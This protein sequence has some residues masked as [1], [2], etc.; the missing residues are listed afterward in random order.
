MAKA[1]VAQT[2]AHPAAKTPDEQDVMPLADLAR[3]VLDRSIRPRAAA[4]RRLA[5]G[6]LANA[7]SPK[8]AKKAKSAAAAGKA[9]KKGGGKKRKLAKIP[10][11]KG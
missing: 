4:V 11:S 7:A 8:K 1:P 6:V 9:G 3:A 2:T 5:E 10:G